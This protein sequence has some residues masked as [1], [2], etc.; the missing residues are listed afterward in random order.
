MEQVSA[1]IQKVSGDWLWKLEAR[2]RDSRDNHTALVG[3]FEYTFVGVFDSFWDVGALAEYQYDS[4]GEESQSSAQNDLFVGTR[5]ALNDAEGTEILL[6]IS[7]DLDYNSVR[8]GRI[9]ASARIDNNW[10]WRANA[11][12]FNSDEP[13]DFLYFIRKDDFVEVAIE[14]YF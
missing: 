2:Y 10:K 11:W 13:D 12:W 1:D 4:R 14:Y 3:G 9:E 7:Q 6:G 5:L 8:S